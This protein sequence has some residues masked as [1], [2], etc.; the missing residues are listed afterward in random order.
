[1]PRRRKRSPQHRRS[2][3]CD[4]DPPVPTLDLHGHTADEAV[5]RSELWIREQQLAGVRSIRLITGRGLRS[6]GPPVLRGEIEELLRRLHAGPVEEFAAESAGGA[7]RVQLRP[8]SRRATGA[9]QPSVRGIIRARPELRRRAE[10]A[11]AELGVTATP[12]LIDAE[13]RRLLREESD[14]SA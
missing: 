9:A 1:M 14:Q 13:V 12:E 2:D 10:A 3:R 6:V 5:H 4:W 7:F 11:L 8:L